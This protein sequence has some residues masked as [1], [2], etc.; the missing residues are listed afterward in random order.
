MVRVPTGI[1]MKC[2]GKSVF[3]GVF[4]TS[5][6]ILTAC[7]SPSHG[8]HRG[9]PER[10]D[11]QDRIHPGRKNGINLCKCGTSAS[12][13]PQLSY[14]APGGAGLAA[15]PRNRMVVFAQEWDENFQLWA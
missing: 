3:P 5:S 2:G 8:W 12:W 11:P 1:L 4:C 13:D 7:L 14:P 10:Q 15:A 6:S 9:T